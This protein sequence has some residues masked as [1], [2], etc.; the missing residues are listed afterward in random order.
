MVNKMFKGKEMKMVWHVD[1]IKAS[2]K[3][4]F[5]GNKFAQ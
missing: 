1:D 5:E 2:Y 3:D 4:P